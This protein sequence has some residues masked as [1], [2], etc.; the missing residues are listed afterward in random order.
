LATNAIAATPATAA[1]L[2]S[3][4]ILIVIALIE[5]VEEFLA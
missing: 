3:R 1:A 4:E 2:K 5:Q